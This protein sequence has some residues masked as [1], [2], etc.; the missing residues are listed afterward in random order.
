MPKRPTS[1]QT[2]LIGF[3][4]ELVAYDWLSNRYGSACLWRSHYRRHVINDGDIGNDDL[5]FDIEV[6]RER[7]GPLMFEVKATTTDDMA[8]DLSEK[9]IAV[10]QANAGHDRYRILFVGRV[11]DSENRWVSVLPNPL[12][13]QGRGRY[14]IVG[15]GIRYE[16]ALNDIAVVV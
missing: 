3:M 12:S 9:E 2:E 13:T 15:C 11:N 10:A 6:L 16:F 1:D 8:F 7:R 14:R 4:G 5:G